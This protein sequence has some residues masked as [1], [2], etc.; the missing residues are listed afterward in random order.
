MCSTALGVVEFLYTQYVIKFELSDENKLQVDVQ[1]TRSII[2]YYLK[3]LII[4]IRVLVLCVGSN[5]KHIIFF[6]R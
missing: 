5:F 2:R 6:L 4:I 3:S 1:S